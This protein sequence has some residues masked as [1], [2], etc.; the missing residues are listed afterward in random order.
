MSLEPDPI[1]LNVKVVLF[2]D[3]MLYY[4]LSGADPDLSRHFKVLADFDDEFERTTDNEMMLAR[5]IGSMAQQ[6]G[7]KPLDRD[8]VARV[9]EHAARIADDQQ[10]L[11]LTRRT[12]PRPVDRGQSLGRRGRTQGGD[13]GQMSSTRSAN[14]SSA[15]RAFASSANR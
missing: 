14:R 13:Q 5:M 2:G 6:E 3:R 12:D 11:T 15:F 10:R 4:M 8:A 7:L 9:I 1:P